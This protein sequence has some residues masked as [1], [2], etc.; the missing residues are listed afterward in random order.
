MPIG[1]FNN[2]V[3]RD[4]KGDAVDL[5][6]GGV[7]PIVHGI[8]SLALERALTETNTAQRIQ[9]LAEIGIFSRDFGRELTQSL[10]FLMTLRLDAQLAAAGA[11]TAL[12]RPAELS[13][14]QR[15]LLRDAFHVVKQFREIVRHHFNLG[16]F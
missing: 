5:K 14:M 8:R 2:L 9:R 15:D 10:Y 16:T 6:K 13:S 3:M 7:F 11:T 1:F 4:G 12:V